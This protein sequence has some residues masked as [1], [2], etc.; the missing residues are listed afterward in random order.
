MQTLIL[1]AGKELTF[2]DIH[3]VYT[4]KVSIT[5]DPSVTKVL[6][7]SQDAI[8]DIAKSSIIYGVNTGFGPMAYTYIPPKKQQQLQYN[9]VRSHACGMGDALPCSTVRAIMLIRLQTLSQGH[10]AVSL[11]VLEQLV[12]LLE[13]DITPVI[14]EHGSVGA[15]GDLVQLAHIALT[16]I[17][18]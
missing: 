2:A 9:L 12:T 15:S 5:I 13:N 18:E 11:P 4:Q 8:K 6:Q 1:T 17:G 3:A 7:S 16:L 10:S 14:P